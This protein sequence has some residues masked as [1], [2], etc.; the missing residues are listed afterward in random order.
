MVVRMLESAKTKLKAENDLKIQTQSKLEKINAKTKRSDDIEDISNGEA[1]LVYANG[2]DE[3]AVVGNGTDTEV[4]RTSDTG[5]NQNNR[6][7]VPKDRM[8]KLK[9]LKAQA[10]DKIEAIAQAK[11]EKIDVNKDE[12]NK[13]QDTHNL[14][15]FDIEE[16]ILQ[17]NHRHTQLHG[18][19]E[20]QDDTPKPKAK[21]MAATKSEEPDES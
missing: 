2:N 21:R 1:E 5:A 14:E 3:S 12:T 18:L 8:N 16:E 15:E 17:D 7:L 19:A 9:M 13:V 20:K 4:G 11:V 6:N 10:T